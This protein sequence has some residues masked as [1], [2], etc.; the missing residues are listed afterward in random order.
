MQERRCQSCGGVLAHRGR[1][2]TSVYCSAACRQRAYRLRSTAESQTPAAVL[3]DIKRQV[4]GL[5]LEPPAAF[6]ADAEALAA[7]ARRLRR[8][9][10]NVTQVPVTKS[11]AP[12]PRL[13]DEADFASLVGTHRAW[14]HLHC[15]RMVSSYDDAEDLVQETL[16][17]AWRDRSGFEGRAA[18][19]TWLYRIATNVCIDHCAGQAADRSVINPPPASTPEAGSLRNVKPGCNPIRTGCSTSCRPR[20]NSRRPPLC[21]GR[22]WNW[23]F[24][25]LSSTCHP[26][27]VPC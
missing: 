23:P 24:S 9:A 1:G 20:T 17:K 16:L 12:P 3:A 25:P 19:R 21:R 8:L 11:A 15:Y 2:R 4:A 27:S 18:T 22:P 6:R 26:V 13:E 5:A 14:L 10:Q 7:S